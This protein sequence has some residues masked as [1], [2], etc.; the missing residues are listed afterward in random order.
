MTFRSPVTIGLPISDTGLQGAGVLESTESL[1]NLSVYCYTTQQA[2]WV[3]KTPTI[4]QGMT[5]NFDADT[6]GYCVI[7]RSSQF[8]ADTF[9]GLA[10]V[11]NYPN[12][13]NPDQNATVIRY[14]LSQDAKISIR[15][16]DVSGILVT[17]LVNGEEKTRMTNYHCFWDG[18]NDRGELVA[19][20]V[21]FCVIESSAGERT[22]R[23]IAV[24][25]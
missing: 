2:T 15:I 10:Q 17:T 25:R 18:R 22:I 14:R 13:F 12:P 4:R 5:I 24:L 21:Y 20:N 9:T 7:V 11:Y 16:Y 23:K 19:N 3:Q 8:G 1:D 6:L